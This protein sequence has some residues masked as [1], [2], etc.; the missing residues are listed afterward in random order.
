ME[1]KLKMLN[2]VKLIGATVIS[3]GVIL[4]LIGFSVSGSSILTPIGIGTVVG[5]TFIFLMGNFF[6][7]TE[8]MLEKIEEKTKIIRIK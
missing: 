7:I 5:G 2:A 4:F 8:E 3:I 1:S 6:V